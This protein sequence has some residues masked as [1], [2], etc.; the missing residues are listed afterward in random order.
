MLETRIFAGIKRPFQSTLGL[1]AIVLTVLLWAVAANVAHSLFVAGVKPLELAGV[2]AMVATFGLAILDSFV[3]R[4]RAKGM[5]W[6]EFVLGLILVG[7]VGADYVAIQLLPVAVAI[8]LL[9]MAPILVVLWN[10]L[11]SRRAP[12]RSVLVALILSLLGVV[13]VSNLLVD[14]ISHINWFGLFVGLTTAV[15]FA[16]YIVL[17]EKLSTTDE[18][19]GVMLKTFA[20]AS[21]FWLVYQLPQGMPWTLL[22]PE[23]FLKV[24]IMGIAGNLLPYLLFFWCL[25]RVP[26]ERAAI[27]ATLEPAIAGVLAWIW[28][29]QALTVI[30]LVGGVL[31]VSAIT[32]MQ[33]K[34][35]NPDPHSKQLQ[36]VLPTNKE[37]RL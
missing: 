19:V 17:S 12:S 9:F 25:Q 5:S 3:G 37:L 21:L 18:P 15:C 34:T 10:A 16:A 33:L 13:L 32:W 29:G 27:V 1:V 31:I 24:L 6:K 23:N 2:S 7:L 11:T 36:S 8:V 28:F 26:A 20:V 35:T 14:D 22:A 4:T 30:Q